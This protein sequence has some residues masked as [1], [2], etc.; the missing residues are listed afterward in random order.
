MTP[1]EAVVERIISVHRDISALKATRFGAEM[2]KARIQ[3]RCA[4]K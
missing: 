1:S 2:M 4:R 3:L